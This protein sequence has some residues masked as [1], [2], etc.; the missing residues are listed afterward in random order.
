MPIRDDMDSTAWR[1]SAA[2][3]RS[4]LDL[5]TDAFFLIFYLRGGN[6]PGHLEEFRKDVSRMLQNLDKEGRKYGHPEEDVKAARYALCALI[7]ETILNSGWEFKDQWASRPLQLEY[8]DEHVAGER[9][10]VL[11][12]RVRVKGARKV[13]LLE[14]FCVALVLGFQGKY[15]LRGHDELTSLTEEIAG[16]VNNY[17]GGPSALSPNWRIPDERAKQPAGVV[18]R[19]VWITGLASIL[20]LILVFVVEKT[21]LRGEV[22]K[23]VDNV[24]V[25]T[26]L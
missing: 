9:F 26:N 6:D 12:D 23:I 2:R 7:D 22:N 13:D 16:E 21:W 15:K 8:F 14:V 24:V 1:L 18:P 10:F 3:G 5:C 4:L 25:Q 19:W 20:L 17:R 11:L